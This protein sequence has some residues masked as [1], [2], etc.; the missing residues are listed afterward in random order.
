MVGANENVNL[1]GVFEIITVIEKI[2]V[3]KVYLGR[4][5]E[6]KKLHQNEYGN[7]VLVNFRA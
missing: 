3:R 2:T 1:S 4:V 5:K 6:R 7:I